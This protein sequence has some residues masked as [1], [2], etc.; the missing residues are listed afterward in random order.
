MNFNI[1]KLVYVMTHS[2]AYTSYVIEKLNLA[3]MVRLQSKRQRKQ[4]NQSMG[5]LNTELRKDGCQLQN[6]QC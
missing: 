4:C 3:R 5:A 1:D 6:V 2:V